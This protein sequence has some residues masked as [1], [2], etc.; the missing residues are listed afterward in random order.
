ML[1]TFRLQFATALKVFDTTKLKFTDEKFVAIPTNTYHFVRDSTRKIF[2]LFHHWPTDTKYHL[3]ASKDFAQDSAGRKLL[4]VDTIS[5]QTKKDIEYGEVRI[6][7]PN[8]NLS[9]NPVLQFI[10][11]DVVK[12][13]YS[14]V[15][16]K[17][18]KVQLF[19]PGEYELRLLFDDNK[20][21]VWDSGEFFGKHRQPEKVLPIGSTKKKFNVKAN[22]DNEVDITL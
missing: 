1:D 5:F 9:R 2:F 14:F 16:R 7:I 8:L 4:K 6:R 21:G 10:Q 15:N 3:I 12:F 13:S 22:W 11:G 18:F 17:E 20:N 19:A